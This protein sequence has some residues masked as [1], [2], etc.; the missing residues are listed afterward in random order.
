MARFLLITVVLTF[1]LSV[2]SGAQQLLSGNP[3]VQIAE[4]VR[5]HP[6][7]PDIVVNEEGNALILWADT[8]CWMD[9]TGVPLNIGLPPGAMTD[10]FALEDTSW[11]GVYRQGSFLGNGSEQG[12]AA[13]YFC[14]SGR[15]AVSTDSTS[16]I[17]DT[18]NVV[19][20]PEPGSW[21]GA[22]LA[23]LEGFMHGGA[24]VL[25][26][27]VR[28]ATTWAGV[29]NAF[30]AS[31]VWRWTPASGVVSVH[32]SEKGYPSYSRMDGLHGLLRLSPPSAE[33]CVLYQRTDTGERSPA[34]FQRSL[35]RLNIETGTVRE[36]VILD[37][38]ATEKM[39]LS[40]EVL[41]REDGKTDILR[42]N[43]VSDAIF[44]ERFSREGALLE[45]LPVFG[46]VRVFDVTDH[47]KSRDE[48]MQRPWFARGDF[49][50]CPLMDG[51]TLATWS[52]PRG[53]DA[54]IM[55]ALYDEDW[56]VAGSIKQAHAPG[57]GVRIFPRL[58]VRGDRVYLTWHNTS[59]TGGE[60][61]LRVFTIDN[62]TR[63]E[64]S[65]SKPKHLH[66]EVWPQ[67]ARDN[68]HLR[69]ALP[70][71]F[72]D[73]VELRCVDLLGRVRMVRRIPSSGG[74]VSTEVDTDGWRPGLY[75]L[76][77]RAGE[78]VVMKRILVQPK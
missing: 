29:S 78:H 49:D 59:Q 60:L 16:S 61:W 1:M 35:A 63:T 70:G 38:L 30:D 65:P 75:L 21:R 5:K 58:A 44:V 18:Y 69:V 67:P 53:V 25:I 76:Q 33:E 14:R 28:G 31:H 36:P 62:L 20:M 11:I 26:T 73:G 39:D 55:V 40:D 9:A 13:S 48:A 50:L 64:H 52:E 46:P 6:E 41:T 42:R 68:V 51:R 7:Q 37:T 8:A 72:G 45:T 4:R 24:A 3:A 32:V 22:E 77:V 66:V 74:V 19:Y 23:S 12:W 10:L 57:A 43:L 15:G 71:Y 54:S 47:Y 34:A 2:D 27:T 56:Q 17:A